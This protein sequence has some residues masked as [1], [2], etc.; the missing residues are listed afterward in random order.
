M[1][2]ISD[3]EVIDGN[4]IKTKNR[5]IKKKNSFIN[6]ACLYAIAEARVSSRH[7]VL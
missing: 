5:N 1:T 7:Q 3:E 6:D 4:N 2:F